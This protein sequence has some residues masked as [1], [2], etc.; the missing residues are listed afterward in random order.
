MTS[1]RRPAPSGPGV[2][3]RR[4]HLVAVDVVRVVTILGVIGV[5][6]VSLTVTDA[7]VAGAAFLSVAHVTRSV[8]LTLSAFILTY[9]AVSRPIRPLPFWRRRYLLVVVPYVTW[10]VVYFFADR[11]G[12]SAGHLGGR[13]LQDLLSGGAR[14]HLYFLL[15]TFQLYA[16]FPWVFAWLRRVRPAP[17]LTVSAL[18]EVL[19][20]AGTHWWSGAP[21]VL[22]AIL[23]HPGSW[24]WS[25]QFYVVLGVVAALHFEELTAWMT[26]HSGAVMAGVVPMAGAAL[27]IYFAQ[28]E[29]WSMS[30]AQASE[31]F[32]PTV[33]VLAAGVVAAFYAAGVRVDAGAGTRSR[34]IL[35]S[36]ADASF[37]TYLAHP[38]L[39]QGLLALGGAIGLG[40]LVGPVPAVAQVALVL[41]VLVPLTYAVTSFGVAAARRTPLSLPLT[42]RRWSGSFVSPAPRIRRSLPWTRSSST[43]PNGAPN[44][45]PMG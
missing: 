13:F 24:L 4:R 42:G 45:A 6:A 19:F 35:G 2:A 8:F 15:L 36:L 27:G 22:G 5:H 34:R 18:A 10:T 30:P 12:G 23:S 17:I 21:G 37:G 31:V 40:T 20:T 3:P 38:L 44:P 41:L 25:Y 16:V 14:Y 26:A 33:A 32:Q 1:G 39:L 7:S 9:Q 28:V 29:L 11:V 43:S